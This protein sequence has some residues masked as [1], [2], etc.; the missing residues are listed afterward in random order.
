[1][2]AYVAHPPGHGK[3][4]D[5]DPQ[6]SVADV[7]DNG[8]AQ[9]CLDALQHIVVKADSPSYGCTLVG[10]GLQSGIVYLSVAEIAFQGS[11][12]NPTGDAD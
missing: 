3:L 10:A 11:L 1:M 8:V 7:R 5:V 9:F 2:K 4:F 12:I 6:G